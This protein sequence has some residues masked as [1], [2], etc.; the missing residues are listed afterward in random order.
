[1]T[2]I[3]YGQQQNFRRIPVLGLVPESSTTEPA[4][5]VNG[6][7]WLDTSLSPARLKV[8]ENGA[9]V[10]ASQT[11]TL[12]DSDLGAANGVASLDGD[13]KVPIAQIPTGQTGSTVP[14]G[15]DAR[16][17]DERVPTDGSV[18][19]G[20]AGAGVKIAAATITAANIANGTITDTQIAAAN[21]DGA[22]GTASLRTLGTGAQ[23]AVSGTDARLS[24]ERVPTD[25][26]V[27]TA[28]FAAAAIDPAA[29]TA[30]AR[31]LGYTGNAAMPGVARLDQIAAPTASVS[32][33]SQKITGLL[34]GTNPTDA[35]NLSQA[36]AL[37]GGIASI[38]APVRVATSAN[39]NLASPGTTIDGVTMANGERFLAYGQSTGTQNGIYVF[40]GSGSA[41]TRATDADETGEI[42]DGTVVVV[43][44]GTNASKQMMQTATPSGAI[45]TWTQTWIVSN[46]SGTAYDA[47]N[48]LQLTGQTFS[49]KKDT[50][51]ANNYLTV[52]ADGVGVGTTPVVLGGTGATTA[53]GARTNLG[54][55]GV[56][57]AVLGAITAGVEFNVV[58]NLNTT[59][60]LEPS[61]KI[62]AD[63][64]FIRFGSRVIDANTVGV[65]AAEA[66][67]ASAIEV[68]VVG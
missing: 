46:V 39:V 48:G 24:D 23:Q 14:L 61:F 37:S 40:N 34:A 41:A 8:R 2:T 49:V 31:T 36:Q 6:Q 50:T 17:T 62:A 16:F 5:A 43:G 3:Q 1:M 55:A 13:T 53:A 64:T 10:L 32:M 26:S 38:K 52:T 57:T 15:N 47:G 21:K 59:R 29:G 25:S 30:G 12:L 19:G 27:T 44:E 4:S 11:G 33:N 56:Y 68:T 20:A 42:L 51:D 67:S 18:T 65:T 54:A 35:V 66:W 28:K 60:P 63:G 22:A 45:G 9:W 58:H 7:L